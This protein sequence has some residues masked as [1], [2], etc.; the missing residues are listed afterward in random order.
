MVR[1][2][3]N[4]S[5]RIVV[6]TRSFTALPCSK[7]RHSPAARPRMNDVDRQDAVKEP[8]SN[9]TLRPSAVLKRAFIGKIRVST[10]ARGAS[11]PRPVLC[12]RKRPA[13]QVQI[14]ER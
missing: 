10:V 14:G 12:L 2:A 1:T 7:R 3:R 6:L 8:L 4:G 13:G 5:W 11:R 9:A